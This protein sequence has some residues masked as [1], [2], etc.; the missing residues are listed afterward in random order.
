MSA[1][2]TTLKRI[3]TF[4]AIKMKTYKLG[5]IIDN[6]RVAKFAMNAGSDIVIGKDPGHSNMVRVEHAIMSRQ[7]VQLMMDENGELYLVDL[8]STNGVFINNRKINSNVPYPL[9]ST[10]AISFGEGKTVQLVFNPDDYSSGKVN[11]QKQNTLDPD[12]D[13]MGLFKNKSVLIIGRSSACD[14]VLSH[15]AISKSHASI[16]KKTNGQFYL[17][18]LGS[19]NGTFLNGKHITSEV[20]VTEKDSILIG[21]FQISLKGESKRLSDEITIR[22]ERIVKEYKGGYQGLKQ[23]SF[24]IPSESMLAVMGPSGCGK[25]TLL[26]ALCGDSPPTSGSVYMLGF[27]F[28]SHYDFL[29][30]Q[31]GYVPQDDIVHRELTIDQSLYY[32]AKLRMPQATDENITEKINEVLAELNIDHIRDSL[33]G[34]ISGGQRKRVSIA[35]EILTDPMI[36]FLDEP[37]SPLDPQTIEEFLGI[38]RRLAEKGTTVITVTHKPDDLEFMDSVVFMAEGGHIAYQDSVEGCLDYFKVKSI[39]E[40]YGQLEGEKAEPWIVKWKR[41]MGGDIS[42]ASSPSIKEKGK[43]NPLLQYRWLTQRF[44]NIKL[45]DK[46]STAVMICQAPIIAALICIIFSTVTPAVPFLIAICAIWFGTSNAA[47][48]IVG[49]LPIYKRERMFNQGIF[50]YIF[51]K[52]TVLGVFSAAQALLFTVILTLFYSNSSDTTV[53]WNNPMMTFTWMLTISIASSMMGLLL[54]AVA[55]TPEKVMTIVPIALIPQIMLAGVV[56]P[57]QSKFVEYLSYITLSRWGTEGLSLIQEDVVVATPD[58]QQVEGTGVLGDDNIMIEPKFDV[59]TKDSIMD[60]AT[61]LNKSF[62]ESYADFGELQNTLKLDTTAIGILT[63]IFFVGIY[64]ALK[65][66]DPIKIK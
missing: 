59:E 7:H 5:I 33:V 57:I 47:R 24:E 30:T 61:S 9:K 62:H 2:E 6:K 13:I 41:T 16:E 53:A 25:S 37:T 50:P 29:K 22:A 20:K 23:S 17:K 55:S 40:V 49:E 35:V 19:L 32:A 11:F 21:R 27:E 8:K 36:L 4:H 14:V 12:M 52:I 58:V 26:K 65:Q 10:D 34:K 39:R 51:S 64:F 45:N 28:N 15:Q 60:A 66:K 46:V 48:E 44:F 1:V 56:A 63:L 43:S 54:S 38:L 3:T 42:G 31:I 18:D